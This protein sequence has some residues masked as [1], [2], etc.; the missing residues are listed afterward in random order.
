VVFF[1]FDKLES[2]ILSESLS[3][4]SYIR[5]VVVQV[6]GSVV[7]GCKNEMPQQSEK[8]ENQVK[9]QFV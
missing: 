9:A 6:D 1:L 8:P 5:R 4:F 7:E 2:E 3:I